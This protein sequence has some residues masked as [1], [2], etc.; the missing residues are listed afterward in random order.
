MIV[1]DSVCKINKNYYKQI[2]T[3]Q[4]KHKAKEEKLVSFIAKDTESSSSC[5]HDDDEPIEEDS[6]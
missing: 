2:F 6:G 5:D 4:S 3:E 1:H